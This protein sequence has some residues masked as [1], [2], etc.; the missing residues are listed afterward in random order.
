[1]SLSTEEYL[2][3]LCKKQE[4]M[5]ALLKYLCWVTSLI[6]ILLLGARWSWWPL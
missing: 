6:A 3:E 5:I 2:S 4:R 1:M